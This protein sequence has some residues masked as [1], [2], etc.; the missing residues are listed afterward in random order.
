[1]KTLIAMV[2]LNDVFIVFASYLLTSIY[3]LMIFGFP[4]RK[5]QYDELS[6]LVYIPFC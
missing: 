2:G 5:I 4:T 6:F 1:M 3:L